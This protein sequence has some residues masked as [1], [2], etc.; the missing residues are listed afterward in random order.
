M[1]DIIKQKVNNKNSKLQHELENAFD[2]ALNGLSLNVI[3]S[4]IKKTHKIY[5]Q[6]VSS[7]EIFI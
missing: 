3:Q 6:F 4:C 5:Q 1:W 7:Y 2:E